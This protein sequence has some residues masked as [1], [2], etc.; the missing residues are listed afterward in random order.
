M[1]PLIPT[2]N[3]ALLLAGL[4]SVAAP[5]FA[6]NKQ[7]LG[8]KILE[9]SLRTLGGEAFL[10][11]RDRTE[12]GRVYSFYREQLTGLA[13]ATIYT[14]YLTPAIPSEPG[15]VYV[16]ERQSFGKEEDYAVLF[17]ETKGWQIT[18]RGARPIPSETLQRDQISTMR[19]LFYILRQRLKEPGLIIESQGTDVFDNQPVDVIDIVDSENNTVTVYIHRSTKLPVRQLFY[20]RDPKTRE[21]IEEATVFSKYRDVGGGVLWPFTIQRSRSGEKIFEIYSESV[22][23]N[24]D[25]PD[26]LFTLPANL[27]I[28]PPAR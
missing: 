25:L 15:K 2:C 6:Q 17:D 7:E 23:I 28:L 8:R 26:N 24:Q 18:F 5:I 12:T 9:E 10:N 1:R 13:R 22:E 3:A 4:L 14:R 27:K 21:R 20:R 16:R 11:V 19:N